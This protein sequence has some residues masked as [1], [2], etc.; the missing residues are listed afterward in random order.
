VYLDVTMENN[1]CK[2][3]HIC[4]LNQSCVGRK[5]VL[6]EELILMFCFHVIYRLRNHQCNAILQK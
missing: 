1:L 3:M 5:K 2:L 6:K 4:I